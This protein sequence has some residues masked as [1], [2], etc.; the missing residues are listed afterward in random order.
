MNLV[1]YLFILGLN[2]GNF[3]G[4]NARVN[5]LLLKEYQLLLSQAAFN[6]LH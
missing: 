4:L 2:I 3:S 5:A 6:H 1:N